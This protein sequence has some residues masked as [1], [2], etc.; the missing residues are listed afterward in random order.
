MTIM[1]TVMINLGDRDHEQTEDIDTCSG[2]A[3]GRRR[4]RLECTKRFSRIGHQ[5]YGE[6]N[7]SDALNIG[8]NTIIMT[9]TTMIVIIIIIIIIIIHIAMDTCA[10]LTRNFL[11][12]PKRTICS[13]AQPVCMA[14]LRALAFL[15]S[16]RGFSHV[17]G[18]GRSKAMFTISKTRAFL[19]CIL[20]LEHPCRP[21]SI[22]NASLGHAALEAYLGCLQRKQPQALR[23]WKL[24][25]AVSKG[26]NLKHLR[27]MHSQI[28]RS[29]HADTSRIC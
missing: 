1:T 29:E 7:R 15:E 13:H 18:L 26:N 22:A 6:N 19:S 20:W 3:L 21:K 2:K 27:E 5:W 25:W 12:T 17:P 8:K 14:G 4:P 9:I 11:S 10:G 16:P 24:I 28:S 23:H